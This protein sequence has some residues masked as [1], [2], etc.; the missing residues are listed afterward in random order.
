[1]ILAGHREK[2]QS[3]IAM[4]T[5]KFLKANYP[6]SDLVNTSVMF[7]AALVAN[8]TDWKKED[9]QLFFKYYLMNSHREELKVYGNSFIVTAPILLKGVALYEEEKSAYRESNHKSNHVSI[10]NNEDKQAEPAQVKEI[11][12]DILKKTYAEQT[13]N[14]KTP[15]IHESAYRFFDPVVIDSDYKAFKE[16]ISTL[17]KSDKKVWIEALEKQDYLKNSQEEKRKN[18]LLDILTNP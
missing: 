14:W 12:K 16:S 1:M 8:K 17:K 5:V 3:I 6:Q 13:K 9:I 7:S 4:A 2:L 11:V 15:S 10:P 18:E